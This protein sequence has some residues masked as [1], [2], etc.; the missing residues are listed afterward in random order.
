MNK[1]SSLPRSILGDDRGSVA[2][3]GQT[4]VLQS[5]IQAAPD[6]IEYARRIL[7]RKWVVLGTILATIAAGAWI[8]SGLPRI[9]EATATV[10]IEDG[11][12]DIVQIREFYS[13]T[14]GSRD[15]FT[16]QS[17]FI[18]SRN[19]AERVVKQFAL[20]EHP[21]FD[22]RQAEPTLIGTLRSGIAR[23]LPGRNLAEPS[24]HDILN[25]VVATFTE[26]L[27]VEPLR[28][29]QL[30]KIHFASKDPTLAAEI[31]NAVA[32]AYITADMDARYAVT[33]QAHS[34]LVEQVASLRQNLSASEQALQA[35]RD[36]K[37]LIDKQS[38]A[39]GGAARQL[40]TITQRLVEA[41]VRRSQAEQ[42]YNQI[43]GRSPQANESAP[44]VLANASVARAREILADAQRRMADAAL[45][46]GPSHPQYQAIEADLESAKLRLTEAVEAVTRGIAKEFE[47]ARAVEKSLEQELANSRTVIRGQNRDELELA[48][49]EQEVVTNRQLYETFLARL[50]E[51]HLVSDIQNP[52]ARVIDRAVPPSLPAKPAK[53]PLML[54]F[55]VAGVVLGAAAALVLHRL[56]DTLSSV[57]QVEETLALPVITV[58]PRLK[59]K[60]A[61]NV[62]RMFSMHPESSFSEAIRTARTA[63]R[64]TTV[65]RGDGSVIMV[66]SSLPGEGKSTVA[67][68][69][70]QAHAQVS[71][72]LLIE[73]DIRR[74]SYA[75]LFGLAEASVGLTDCLQGE[76]ASH[77]GIVRL[78][79]SR[80]ALMAAG[81]HL[82]AP[83]ELLSSKAFE[84]LITEL[85]SQF[86][87]IIIDTPPVALV[88]DAVTLATHADGIVLA[89]KA[90]STSRRLVRQ[91]LRRLS[92]V[93]TP[94]IGAVV[95]Q[96]DVRRAR[97]YY[98]EYG[99]Y[100]A[101]NYGGYTRTERTT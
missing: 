85:R 86:E 54:V 98:G 94:V 25:A 56:D 16:T 20:T 83:L 30:V 31:A 90:H 61:R 43:R 11:K 60:E 19:V 33:Q 63:I 92:G 67:L 95:N 51:T 79:E 22:P 52:I 14:T 26:K 99:V 46:F 1:P 10:M 66:T 82:E 69:L 29:T 18:A 96:L 21:E 9:Y 35:Y 81:R 41:R 62:Y 97:R 7:A 17:E 72:T 88:S 57:D 74:P 84:N 23:L 34:W 13:G 28:A 4:G 45:R 80:L 64:L 6:L 2:P 73:C 77:Q 37:G 58:L 39:Q 49:Y 78:R 47:T 24:Q 59:G 5:A 55:A 3:P 36:K 93:G 42:Q 27:D 44:A 71:N 48:T 91:S 32:D 65:G 100:D 76:I 53:L 70:A 89:I 87:V 68:N 8:I 75:P 38:A 101:G 12:N 50:K 40:E 15:H